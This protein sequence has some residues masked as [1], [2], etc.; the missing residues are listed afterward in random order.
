MMLDRLFLDCFALNSAPNTDVALREGAFCIYSM[1]SFQVP[2]CHYD[3]SVTRRFAKVLGRDN[4]AISE[5]PN[6]AY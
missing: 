3:C 5:L 6:Y 4:Y 1:R 2:I